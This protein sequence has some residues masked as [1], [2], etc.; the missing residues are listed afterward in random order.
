MTTEIN[1]ATE[2][3]PSPKPAVN[4]RR[5]LQ[6]RIAQRRFRQKKAMEARAASLQA[7]GIWHEYFNLHPQYA[8]NYEVPYMG[9]SAPTSP[10]GVPQRGWHPTI[11]Y[12]IG[13]WDIQLFG[14]DNFYL[15][16]PPA[17]IATPMSPPNSSASSV[18]PDGSVYGGEAPNKPCFP[19][20][21]QEGYP[22]PMQQNHVFR[23]DMFPR[24]PLEIK[25]LVSGAPQHGASNEAPHGDNIDASA[26]DYAE[27]MGVQLRDQVATDWKMHKPTQS[28]DSCTWTSKDG[29]QW[30]PL[31]HTAAKNGNCG[32]IQM[33]LDHNTDVNERNSNGMTALH[34][35]IENSQEDVIMLLLQRGVDVNAEDNSHRT[36]LSMAVSKNS[37]SGVRLCL[38]H[39]ADPKL[40]K[41]PAFGGSL[42]P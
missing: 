16:S 42:G 7:E 5:K 29:E 23:D 15:S 31:L 21:D 19:P 34:V 32:I 13:V 6:N 27:N 18:S 1:P 38:M 11:E 28:I 3:S 9:P 20:Q 39:G 40:A 4:D 2:K 30:E 17:D 26:F 35:A 12:Q 24:A 25:G 37:E 8:G 22:F 10:A 41:V 36:A 33:L 14:S